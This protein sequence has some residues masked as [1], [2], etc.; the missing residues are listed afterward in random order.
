MNT[1]TAL[2]AAL[3]VT[4]PVTLAAADVQVAQAQATQGTANGTINTVDP[5]KGILN[6]TH[7]PI[8]ALGWPAMTMDFGVAPGVDLKGLAKGAKV[9]FTVA[10]LSDGTFRITAIKPAGK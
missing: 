4:G 2:L 10:K 7:D 9:S 6:M 5:A 8:P 3:L 1:K